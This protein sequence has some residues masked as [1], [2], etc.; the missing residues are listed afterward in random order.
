MRHRNLD[1][2]DSHTSLGRHV[3]RDPARHILLQRQRIERGKDGR[4][5]CGPDVSVPCLPSY[6]HDSTPSMHC[7]TYVPINIQIATLSAAI[8]TTIDQA[9]TGDILL[10]NTNQLAKALK[11]SVLN[12]LHPLIVNHLIRIRNRSH[13]LLAAPRSSSLLG[14]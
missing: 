4:D 13:Q 10:P 9:R 7:S 11:S 3:I 6:R 2:H 1:V 8:L 5:E 12:R 14:R